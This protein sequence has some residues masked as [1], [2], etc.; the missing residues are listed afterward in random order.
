VD[1]TARSCRK[2]NHEIYCELNLCLRLCLPR[3]SGAGFIDERYW[4]VTA[5]GRWEPPFPW[6]KGFNH[7]YLHK[8]I[9]YPRVTHYACALPQTWILA[10]GLCLF[11]LMDEVHSSESGLWHWIRGYERYLSKCFYLDLLS[12]SRP[13]TH[14]KVI[15]CYPSH[16]PSWTHGQRQ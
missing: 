13:C 9:A 7:K 14:S 6:T 12:A 2:C 11:T 15:L 3:L 4:T 5:C 1:V 16:N 8:S 10:Q